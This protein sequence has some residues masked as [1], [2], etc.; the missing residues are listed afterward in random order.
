VPVGLV[1]SS[2]RQLRASGHASYAFLGVRTEQLSPQ[3]AQTLG[4]P[5]STGAMIT[6]VVPGGPADSAGLRGAS[7]SIHF[8][9]SSFRAGGDVIVAVDGHPIRT[10]SDLPIQVSKL[11]PGDTA[12]LDIIRGGHRM[13]VDVKLGQ[14]P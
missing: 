7:R 14:R 8:Q 10:T 3:L 5:I 2:L 6:S 9:R 13:T 1:N 4:I 11:R 12:K